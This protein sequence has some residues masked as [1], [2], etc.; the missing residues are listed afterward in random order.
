MRIA[1]SRALLWHNLLWGMRRMGG[2]LPSRTVKGSQ[3]TKGLTAQPG[4]Q[5]PAPPPPSGDNCCAI[6]Q[7]LRQLT[8]KEKKRCVWQLPWLEAWIR[9]EHI[10]SCFYGRK[11]VA[12]QTSV[13]RILRTQENIHTKSTLSLLGY[14]ARKLNTGCPLNITFA[15]A[16]CIINS[17]LR[18][19]CSWELYIELPR[20]LLPTRAR[21]DSVFPLK[22]C[23]LLTLGKYIPFQYHAAPE[24]ELI[25]FTDMLFKMILS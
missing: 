4:L 12:L 15:F 21:K 19:R 11:E 8:G 20:W 5:L 14:L 17:S 9:A 3:H 13:P 18:E 25:L 23:Y 10:L 1:S 16:M 2:I 7:R 6:F 22:L 24:Q